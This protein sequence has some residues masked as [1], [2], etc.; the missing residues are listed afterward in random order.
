LGP[1]EQGVLLLAARGFRSSASDAR[2]APSMPPKMSFK[3]GPMPRSSLLPDQIYDDTSTYKELVGG[4]MVG[5]SGHVP[6]SRDIDFQSPLGN[7][8]HFTPDGGKLGQGID[9]RKQRDARWFAGQPIPGEPA[10]YR[11]EA[12]GIFASYSGHVPGARDIIG[13]QSKGGVPPFSV[14]GVPLGQSTH[15]KEKI[16][17]EEMIGERNDAAGARKDVAEK[18]KAKAG[19]KSKAWIHAHDPYTTTAQQATNTWG[20]PVDPKA[21]NK[22]TGQGYKAGYRGHVPGVR[23]NVG[24]SYWSE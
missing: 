5:Y 16:L 10:P 3:K 23:G 4:V 21:I 2:R 11:D 22:A 9:G 8:P 18:K 6:G 24:S 7:L 1:K 20:V 15:F 17:P 13:T 14:E 12:N 19:A